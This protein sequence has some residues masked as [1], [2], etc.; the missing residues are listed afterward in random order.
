MR[1]FE[2]HIDTG[3]S[4]FLAFIITVSEEPGNQGFVN[5]QRGYNLNTARWMG[6]VLDPIHLVYG[7]D[8]HKLLFYSSFR[9]ACFL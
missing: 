7:F 9:S 8:E 2:R 6:L 1:W 3:K 5:R 4:T